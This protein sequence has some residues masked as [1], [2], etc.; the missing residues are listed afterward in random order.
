LIHI[1][2]SLD[3][4]KHAV[5]YG[6]GVSGLMSVIPKAFVAR[7]GQVV[8][9]DARMFV[10]KYGAAAFGQQY[11]EETF[12]AR[13]KRLIDTADV[14]LALPGGVGTVYEVLEVMTYNDL[15][16]WK[17]DPERIRRIVVFNHNGAYD[18]LKQHIR[19]AVE[20]GYVV[21]SSADTV[22]WCD[23][24]DCVVRWLG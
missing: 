19:N 4:Q 21:A 24:V 10:E 20:A 6:G 16:L 13:Q 11:V 9:I 2:N 7:G 18:G 1:A 8:G 23:T 22:V 5:V 15:K 12:D 14:F 17:R 3:S